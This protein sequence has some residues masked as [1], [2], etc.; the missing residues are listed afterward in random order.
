MKKVDAVRKSMSTLSAGKPQITEEL[1]WICQGGFT[2][3][4][5]PLQVKEFERNLRG[6]IRACFCNLSHSFAVSYL[7]Y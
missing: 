4:F 2:E 3:R 1:Y 5:P 6:P 7:S